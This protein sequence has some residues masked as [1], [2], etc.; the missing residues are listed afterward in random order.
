[1]SCVNSSGGPSTMRLSASFCDI[2]PDVDTSSVWRCASVSS[3]VL[4]TVAVTRSRRSRRSAIPASV[5]SA[6]PG[7]GGGAALIAREDRVFRAV[8]CLLQVFT[9]PTHATTSLVV[10]GLHLEVE[11]PAADAVGVGIIPRVSSRYFEVLS[12]TVDVRRNCMVARR[13]A[14]HNGNRE[15]LL[16]VGPEV[17]ASESPAHVQF[18]MNIFLFWEILIY[19]LRGSS[20]PCVV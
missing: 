13:L 4:C 15:I 1:M 20:F 2:K 17:R 6:V 16:S 12:V 18:Q 5:R 10:E 8:T 3:L 11:R 19:H 9:W 7:E 14:T